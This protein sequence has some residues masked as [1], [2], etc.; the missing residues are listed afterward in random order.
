M[1][2]PDPLD[3]CRLTVTDVDVH[4]DYTDREHLIITVVLNYEPWWTPI[5]DADIM[6]EKIN[7]MT[8][9]RDVLRKGGVKHD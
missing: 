7:A 6:F 9:I 1:K 5:D 8:S 3:P 2:S 4:T